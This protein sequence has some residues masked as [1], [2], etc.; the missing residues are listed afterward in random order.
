MGCINSKESAG[1]FSAASSTPA[2]KPQK[3]P[4]RP[5]GGSAGG[6]GG[7][8]G[9]AKTSTK[10]DLIELQLSGKRNKRDNVIAVSNLEEEMDIPI[11]KKPAEYN[12]IIE[13]CVKSPDAF[14]F[15]G[16]RETEVSVIVNAMGV[17]EVKA[18]QTIITKGDAGDA[19]YIVASGTF[20]AS[21]D[22]KKVKSYG[23]GEMSKRVSAN[24]IKLHAFDSVS[25]CI[26]FSLFGLCPSY[27]LTHCLTFSG[28]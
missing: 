16:I 14:F 6:G 2:S 26:A 28:L 24:A 8:N 5:S 22:G 15:T 9:T 19:F 17:M 3:A 7:R 1:N 12:A 20:T 11:I 4:N 23:K 25:D 27:R 21:I 13:A 18:G 10:E